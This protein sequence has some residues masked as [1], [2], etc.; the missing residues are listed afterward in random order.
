M[1]DMI[2][3]SVLNL[4]PVN[5]DFTLAVHAPEI[6]GQRTNHVSNRQFL[7]SPLVFTVG[8]AL[9]FGATLTARHHVVRHAFS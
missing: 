9:V 8:C 7:P 6:S 4:L 5:A 3:R 2:L 1:L